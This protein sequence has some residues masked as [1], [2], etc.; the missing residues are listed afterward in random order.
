MILLVCEPGMTK[1]MI[2]DELN[3]SPTQFRDYTPSRL[4]SVLNIIR[5]KLHT[6]HHHALLFG[7]EDKIKPFSLSQLKRM[8]EENKEAEKKA[9]NE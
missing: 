5:G 9:E 7:I 3:K 8:V 1:K 2:C 4:D 6:I